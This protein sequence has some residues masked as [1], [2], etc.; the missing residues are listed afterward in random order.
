MKDR[1]PSETQMALFIGEQGIRHVGARWA[2]KEHPRQP[3][4]KEGNYEF[5]KNTNAKKK[6]GG[7][8]P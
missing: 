6:F 7:N 5:G 3:R 4:R 1:V 8:Q 2:K